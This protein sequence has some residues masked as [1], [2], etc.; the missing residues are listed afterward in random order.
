MKD[1]SKFFKN[2]EGYVTS[3]NVDG[4]EIVVT[5]SNASESRHPEFI[6]KLDR[7]N[8]QF[9][10]K[11][12]EEQYKKAYEI[13]KRI[14]SNKITLV[15]AII[16]ILT[17]GIIGYYG[18]NELTN[19]LPILLGIG[20]IGVTGIVL[21]ETIKSSH[22]RR[23]ET[24]YECIELQDEF[25]EAAKIEENITRNISNGKELLIE[26]R[27]LKEE[28]LVDNIYNVFFIDNASIADLKEI[29]AKLKI[30]LALQKP[31]ELVNEP[32]TR[33]LTKESSVSTEE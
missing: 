9:Y 17:S 12:L 7:E 21:N 27:Q 2:P 4:E 32:K 31:V 11:R 18:V 29:S 13:R 6:Y 23:I 14:T 3:V 24:R 8:L 28:D 16:G 19:L 30:F 25:E 10:E 20:T 26:Q 5:F 15:I 33:K 22:R 1:Y